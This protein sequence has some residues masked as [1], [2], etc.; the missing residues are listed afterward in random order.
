[1]L[2]VLYLT[3]SG[4]GWSEVIGEMELAERATFELQATPSTERSEA[5]LPEPVVNL[6]GLEENLGVVEGSEA[7]DDMITPVPQD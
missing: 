4:V 6:E 1:M 5:Y 3:K 7:F 2:G